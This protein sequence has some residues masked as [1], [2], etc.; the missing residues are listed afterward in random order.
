MNK[1]HRLSPLFKNK[2]NFILNADVPSCIDCKHFIKFSKD[3]DEKSTC[4]L[5]GSKNVVSGK[6]TNQ[7]AKDCRNN[8]N[9]CDTSGIF[10]TPNAN[11]KYILT[12]EEY[13]NLLS[14][15]N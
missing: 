10:H 4:A 14:N 11:E 3:I 5:F 8:P 12:N 9:L 13:I 6:V 7:F 1:I 15:A 2:P